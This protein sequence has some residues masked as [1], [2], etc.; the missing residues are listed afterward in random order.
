VFAM[1]DARHFSNNR[2][3]L[4]VG[5]TMDRSYILHLY[6]TNAVAIAKKCQAAA[7]IDCRS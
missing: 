6:R 7:R 5:R 4:H 1:I 3:R 2:P